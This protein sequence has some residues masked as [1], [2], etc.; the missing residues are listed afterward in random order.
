MRSRPV[1]FVRIILLALVAAALAACAGGGA[2]A[3]A[4]A[5]PATVSPG[6]APALRA[7][8]AAQQAKLTAGDG[9]AADY[10]GYSVAISGAT[11][12]VGAT[13]P[14]GVAVG[15]TD[16]VYV[17]VRSGTTWSQQQKLVAPD[18]SDPG[19]FG[20]SV[21]ISGDTVV[22]SAPDTDALSGAVYV[23]V[24]SGTTW[25]QQQKLTPS[26][27]TTGDRFG[28]AVAISGDTL[29][30]GHLNDDLGANVDQGSAYI[31]VRSGTTWS[32]QQKLIASDGDADDCFGYAVAVSGDTAV[33]GAAKDDTGAE[34]NQGSAYVFV[35]SGATW[36]QQQKLTATDGAGWAYFGGSL[37]LRGDTF[38][39]GAPYA[40]V[41]A[42]VAQ[43]AAYVFVRSGSTW[44]QQQKLTASDGA[45]DDYFGQSVALSGN[46]AVVGAHHDPVGANA[47]Q[48][49][50]YVFTRFGAGW[51]QYR[52]LTAGDGAAEDSFGWSAAIS[53]ATVVVGSLGADVGT[54]AEQGAAYVFR[55]PRPARPAA[56]SP[57]G[58]IGSR[59]PTFRWR[60][61]AGA[62]AY[63][64]RVY[65]GSRLL[66]K[67][68]GI[69]RTSW[70]CTKRLPRQAWLTWK[71]RAR[72]VAGYGAWSAKLR[73]RV[74]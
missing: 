60:A 70:K 58:F 72:N 50:A 48:G 53:D 25:S 74:R 49:S 6:A 71:V 44:S 32:Q 3:T 62:A 4:S 10:F 27:G 37:A 2:A 14:G 34:E 45:A 69:T 46:T 68:V 24:R 20:L 47:E 11:A 43:G 16:G 26:S 55:V 8:L 57:K 64:V 12:V 29:V 41:G 65:K 52:K 31:F 19:R 56:R 9:A 13:A 33:V 42:N 61:V 23:F 38:V 17:F 28:S 18:A 36:T 54:N 67:Q 66:K 51:S 5:G 73:L 40:N 30:V 59:T 39:A 35:R 1:T 21:A 22:V 63:E 15:G 7:V